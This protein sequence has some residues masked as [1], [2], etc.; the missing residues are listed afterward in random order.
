MADMVFKECVQGALRALSLL[1]PMLPIP[2]H[3]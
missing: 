1:E 3:R 2:K